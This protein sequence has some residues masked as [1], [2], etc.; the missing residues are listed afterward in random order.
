MAR[1]L[2]PGHVGI[3]DRFD[4]GRVSDAAGLAL[5]GAQFRK[6]RKAWTNCIG[7][8]QLAQSGVSPSRMANS[9][10]MLVV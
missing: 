10:S 6:S 2:D 8:P 1:A 9:V 4:R 7:L 5:I 3:S